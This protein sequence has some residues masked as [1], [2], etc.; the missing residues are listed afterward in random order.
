MIRVVFHIGFSFN[1]YLFVKMPAMVNTSDF[2]LQY[3]AAD[4]LQP[5]M[6]N[7]FLNWM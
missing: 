3:H 7:T 1:Y 2:R 4:I 6:E 5:Y